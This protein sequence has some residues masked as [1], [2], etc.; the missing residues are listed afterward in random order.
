MIY[1]RYLSCLPPSPCA[2]SSNAVRNVLSLYFNVAYS[3]RGLTNLCPKKTFILIVDAGIKNIFL[4]LLWEQ[5]P[6]SQSQCL[7]LLLWLLF[8]LLLS[9][10]RNCWELEAVLGLGS[11]LWALHWH[12]RHTSIPWCDR[13]G[14]GL[15][16]SKCY[17]IAGGATTEGC[18][19]PH[20]HPCS[21]FFSG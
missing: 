1:Y 2:L 6:H 10:T 17:Q 21:Q 5:F 4:P 9:I 16:P 15:E 20:R 12:L 18:F 7:A 19:L 14:V 8:P 11:G 3:P 13:A